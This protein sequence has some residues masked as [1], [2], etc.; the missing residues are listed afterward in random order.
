MHANLAW[1][2]DVVHVLQE[3]LILDLIV[4]EEE[5]DSLTLLTC[6]AVQEL[7]VFQQ[8]G[9]VVWPVRQGVRIQAKA[10]L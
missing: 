9:H 8:V 1:R 2:Q 4:R 5:G 10:N 7:H 6:C 3:G